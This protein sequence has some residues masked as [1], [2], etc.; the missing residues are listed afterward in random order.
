MAYSFFLKE[1]SRLASA[2]V[3]LLFQAG[4]KIPSELIELEEHARLKK[5]SE[6]AKDSN[7]LQV[8]SGLQG[9]RRD[10][11]DLKKGRVLGKRGDQ[12][13]HKVQRYQEKRGD[14]LTI[15]DRRDN[16]PGSSSYTRLKTETEANP[17]KEVSKNLEVRVARDQ[18]PR[19]DEQMQELSIVPLRKFKDSDIQLFK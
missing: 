14:N 17:G 6:E 7:N 13:E 9:F 12:E 4:Q 1:D 10:G 5:G 2:L 16:N 8:E 19:K 15:G 11:G 3:K 18:R